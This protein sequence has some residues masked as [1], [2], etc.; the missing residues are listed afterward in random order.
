MPTLASSLALAV[1]AVTTCPAEHA[2]LS[3]PSLRYRSATTGTS[4]FLLTVNGNDFRHDSV[5]KWN[6]FVSG[7]DVRE[8]PSVARRYHSRRHRT[9]RHGV[10]LCVQSPAGR[11]DFRLRRNRSNVYHCLRRQ[12]FKR[13]LLHRQPVKGSRQRQVGYLAN[14]RS[15][16][17]RNVRA[18]RAISISPVLGS[19]IW[20]S[21]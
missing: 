7:H 6:G 4:Q 16:E 19:R 21:A 11:H 3:R 9:A 15:G 13:R 8:Q 5:A 2:R 14:Q 17:E 10:G 20:G 18:G 1:L 12:E